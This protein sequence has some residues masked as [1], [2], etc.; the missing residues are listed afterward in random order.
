LRHHDRG[1]IDGIFGVFERQVDF[2]EREPVNVTVQQGVSVRCGWKR[3]SVLSEAAEDGVVVSQVGLT[4]CR[5]GFHQADTPIILE[6]ESVSLET[7]RRVASESFGADLINAVFGEMNPSPSF[8]NITDDSKA[9]LAVQMLD[10][11]GNPNVQAENQ[12]ALRSA[13]GQPVPRAVL[14]ANGGEVLKTGEVITNDL[15]EHARA[16]AVKS[17]LSVVFGETASKN[18]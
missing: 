6:G 8:E 18:P 13:I 14:D 11:D 7:I 3:K 2:L 12:A 1:D 16:E 17:E 10:G 5:A 15:L 9:N 4:G